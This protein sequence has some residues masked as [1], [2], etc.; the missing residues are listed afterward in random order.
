MAKKMNQTLIKLQDVRKQF[1]TKQVLKG[2]SLSIAKGEITAIIGKSGE[3]KSVL[4]KHLIGLIRQDSGKILFENRAFRDMRKHE[5]K[6]LKRRFAYMFQGSALFDSMTVYENIALPLKEKTKLSVSEIEKKVREKM[7]QLDLAEIDNKFPSQLSGG[8]KKRVAL[9]RALVT[10][11]EIVLFDEPTTGLDPIRKNSVHHMISDYQKRFGF[12]GV[13]VS[14]E[15]P[16]IFYISQR[17]A[18]L[19][20]GVIIFEGS[21]DEIQDSENPIIRNFIRGHEGRR[22]VLTGLAPK[23]QAARRFKQEVARLDPEEDSFSLILFT[24][25]HLLESNNQVKYETDTS[26]L[27]N[28]ADLV[29]ENL[30]VTD[31]CSRYGLNKII[32]M[33]P[34]TKIDEAR[35]ICNKMAEDMKQI[36]H[37]GIQPHPGFCFAITAGVAEAKRNSLIDKVVTEAESGRN[38]L[39]EFK[40]C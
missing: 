18:M 26:A 2:V 19:D 5:K 38:T 20:E 9:A 25:E 31:V 22:D 6:T 28:L 37:P 24:V 17:V 30:R 16:D 29:R 23:S 10:N 3:G 35:M 36:A 27:K 13:V 14:H 40:I 11:P 32:A 21:P 8:M 39:Y 12:T 7:D 34:H 1:G 4:L 15:I 33:L